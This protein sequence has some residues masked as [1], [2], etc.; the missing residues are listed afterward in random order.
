MAITNKTMHKFNVV[1]DGN[2]TSYEIVDKAG[3][4]MAVQGWADNSAKAFAAGEYIEKDGKLYKFKT[5][6]AAGSAWNASEVEET[7]IGQELTDLKDAITQYMYGG[8]KSF[9]V[10]AGKN[11]LFDFPLLKGESYQFNNDCGASCNVILLKADGTTKTVSSNIENGASIV[12]VP[13]AEDYIAIRSWIPSGATGTITIEAC[14]SILGSKN[15]MQTEIVG[16]MNKIDFAD[17]DVVFSEKQYEISS[18]LNNQGTVTY[19]WKEIVVDEPINQYGMIGVKCDDVVG[20]VY[21]APFFIYLY[22]ANH[23]QLSSRA[24]RP[25]DVKSWLVVNPPANAAYFTIQLYVS[26]SGGLT[27][28]SAVFTNI[29]VCKSKNGK[30]IIKDE[31][32]PL[33]FLPYPYYFK[34]SY[35]NGKVETILQKME[36]GNGNYDAFIFCTDQHWRSNAKQSPKL[37]NYITERLCVPR[38]FMGGDYEDGVSFSAYMAYRQAYNGEIYNILGNHEYM[39]GQISDEGAWSRRVN[40]DATFFACLNGCMT[41]AVFGDVGRNYYYVDNTV[42]KMRYIILSIFTDESAVDFSSAQ[43]TWFANTALNL[44]SGYTAIV[45]AHHIASVDH[46]TGALTFPAYDQTIC[47]IV[48]AYSG[49]GEIA[50]LIGGHT[51]FDGLGATSGGIPVFVTSCDKNIPYSQGGEE[52]LADRVTGTIDEQVFDVFI[53]NKTT[54]KVTAVRVGCPAYNP[55]GEPLQ[56]REANY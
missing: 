28:S 14:Y 6:H 43:Q 36:A 39:D 33:P 55:T 40:T 46:E 20:N 29:C 30:A 50:C 18:I 51:H 23:T 26:Q 45:F 38:M 3:R 37:I 10:E 1:H 48:D 17:G 41:N 52:Y 5:I 11:N 8:Q 25:D 22:D 12:F 27:D 15:D 54:K 47:N 13:D 4:K 21:A 35:L 44:P 9:Y 16:K 42:Q 53:I 19:I 56:I 24:Y 31:S 7:N 49:N 2:T 32:A 34:D